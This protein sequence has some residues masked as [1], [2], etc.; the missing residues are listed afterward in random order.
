VPGQGG[1]AP[2]LIREIIHRAEGEIS[3]RIYSRARLRL[4]AS[5]EAFQASNVLGGPGGRL[6]RFVRPRPPSPYRLYI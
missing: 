5:F 4:Q 2:G 1:V 3:N 6:I